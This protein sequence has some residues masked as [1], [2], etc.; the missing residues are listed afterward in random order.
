MPKNQ[1]VGIFQVIL[2]SSSWSKT[3]FVYFERTNMAS[4]L[5]AL[6]KLLKQL[7][8]TEFKKIKDVLL[9]TKDS[10]LNTKDGLLKT[11]DILLKSKDSCTFF[12]WESQG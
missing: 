1:S 3:F 10:L 5:S 11:E 8:W 4:K 7:I 12:L 2:N 9:K 6:K